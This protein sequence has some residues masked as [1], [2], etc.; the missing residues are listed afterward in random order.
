M[1]FHVNIHIETSTNVIMLLEL[2]CM[3][4]DYCCPNTF[5]RLVYKLRKC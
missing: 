3:N 2:E 5:G 1:L 4:T